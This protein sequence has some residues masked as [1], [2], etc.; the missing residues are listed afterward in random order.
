MLDQIPEG[1]VGAGEKLA[2]TPGEP[3]VE[4]LCG[5]VVP[6]GNGRFRIAVDRGA[7]TT[8]VALRKAGSDSIRSVVQ[9]AGIDLNSL[10]NSDG[11]P[12]VI[13]FDKLPDV[14]AGTKSLPLSAKSD[15][16]L[17]VEFT[18]ISGPATIE[19]NNLVF[20]PVPPRT[21]YPLEV[22]VGAWQWGRSTDP[23]VKTS[24]MVKQTFRIL[25]P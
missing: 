13:T 12:Q 18:V 24:D 17:P 8:Y 7:K 6:L 16:G 15:S 23:K 19:G 20:T 14:P 10:R 22:T 1:F 21:K 9:P 4:W 11:A 25:Q 5:P 2:K 3:E